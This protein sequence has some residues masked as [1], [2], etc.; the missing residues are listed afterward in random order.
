M[1]FFIDECLSPLLARRL[2]ERDI[3]ALHPLD[4]GRRGEPDH[5]VLRRCIEEAMWDN[6]AI[7]HR[8]RPW[9][10]QEAPSMVR[11]TISAADADGLAEMR[12]AA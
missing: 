6:R 12:P 9:P 11:T 8:G 5:V 4:V 3:E 1:K 2:N 10:A 7:I